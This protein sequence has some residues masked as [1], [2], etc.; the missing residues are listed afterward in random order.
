M[1]PNSY[2]PANHATPDAERNTSTATEQQ[3]HTQ[4]Q[5]TSDSTQRKNQKQNK[6]TKNFF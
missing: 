5:N 6:Q 3:Q 1:T 4:E 2:P